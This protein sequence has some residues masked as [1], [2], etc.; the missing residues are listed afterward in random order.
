MDQLTFAVEQ[1]VQRERQLTE[2]LKLMVAAMNVQ[3]DAIR[4]LEEHT[5]EHH[6]VINGLASIVEV[7]EG[8]MIGGTDGSETPAS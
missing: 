1:Q 6:E 5:N 7:L 2:A 4:Q 3:N 8:L